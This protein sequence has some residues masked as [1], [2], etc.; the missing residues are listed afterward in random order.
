MKTFRRIN[1]IAITLVS[2]LFFVSVQG[3]TTGFNGPL[4]VSEKNPRYFT[5]NSGRAVCLT[6]SHTWNNLVDMTSASMPEKFDYP[7][8]LEW[9]NRYNH[10]FMRLWAWELL[11]WN[12]EGNREKKPQRLRV[13]PHPWLRSGPGEALDGNLKFDLERFNPEYFTRLEERIKL[14]YDAGIYVSVM[15]FEGWGLQFSPGAFENHPF[16]PGNNI[17]GINGDANGDGSATE[18]HTMGDIRINS[19]Q[20][21]YVMHMIDVLNK[22]DNLLYEISNEN[23]PPST[24]WQYDMIRFIK[25]YESSLP[26]QHPVGMTFQYRGGSNKVLFDGPADWISPNPEGGYRDNPPPADGSKVILN[27]TDHLWG[28]GGNPGWIWKSFLRG[29]NPLFMD[30]YDCRVLANACDE[31]WLE[32][33]RKGQGFTRLIA[34]RTDLI[35]LVPHAEMAS[36]SYCLANKGLEYLVYLSDTSTVSIDLENAPGKFTAEWFDTGTGKFFKDQ[37]IKGSKKVIMNS[38]SGVKNAVLHLYLKT[39]VTGSKKK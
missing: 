14:A 30:P 2:S 12:T 21:A 37:R 10:N 35:S 27:D 26:K 16:H 3:Q 31:S 19:I 1:F 24:E 38:P 32:S 23:H 17:N 18:I 4:K 22:Y 5:D 8:Y 15:L 20:K 6:G 25:N 13:E 28:L 7:G 9:M 33:M 34:N 29:M 11:S 36:T 39:G